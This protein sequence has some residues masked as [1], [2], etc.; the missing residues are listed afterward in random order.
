MELFISSHK[1]SDLIIDILLSCSVPI[2]N[3]IEKGVFTST[4]FGSLCL[5]SQIDNI[6]T[7]SDT[8]DNKIIV[9][10]GNSFYWVATKYFELRSNPSLQNDANLSSVDKLFKKS[11]EIICKSEK[12]INDC[13]VQIAN[14]LNLCNF[15]FLNFKFKKKIFFSYQANDLNNVKNVFLIINFFIKN[16]SGKLAASVLL[17]ENI[18]T[19]FQVG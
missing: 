13:I 12:F 2:L 3:K 8:Y 16:Y 11:V 4:L 6:S 18:H 19:V 1:N 14:M 9:W 7:L 10:L 5:I 15:F 17:F